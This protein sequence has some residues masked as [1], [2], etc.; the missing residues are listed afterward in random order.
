[1]LAVGC[2]KQPASKTA[3]DIGAGQGPQRFHLSP[4]DNSDS[5]ALLIHSSSSLS[6]SPNSPLFFSFLLLFSSS[7]LF[8]SSCQTRCTLQP[9]TRGGK[10]ASRGGRNSWQKGYC[11]KETRATAE[12]VGHVAKQ[13]TLQRGA[14][15]EATQTRMPLM[16]TRVKP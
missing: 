5:V 7:R 9:V 10:D 6:L 1:M 13:G 12:L 4:A 14:K 16:K 2:E 8:L 11:K 15:K 3:G